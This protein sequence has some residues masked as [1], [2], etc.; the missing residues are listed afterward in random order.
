MD[1]SLQIGDVAR[2]RSLESPGNPSFFA[3]IHPGSV[4]FSS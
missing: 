2:P 4:D 1:T 3:G